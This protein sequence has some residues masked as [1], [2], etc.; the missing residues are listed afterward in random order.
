MWEDRGTVGAASDP[1]EK[2]IQNTILSE[3]IKDKTTFHKSMSKLVGIIIAQCSDTFMSKMKADSEYKEAVR[4]RDPITV[5][6]IIKKIMFTQRSQRQPV[7]TLVSAMMKAMN[8]KQSNEMSVSEYVESF[9][10]KMDQMTI[11]GTMIG[12]AE[13]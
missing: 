6:E 5:L 4:A 7:H 11:F 12:T 9:T 13:V 3:W 1:I 10:N 2:K 8:F